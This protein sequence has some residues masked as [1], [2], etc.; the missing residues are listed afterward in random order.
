MSVKDIKKILQQVNEPNEFRMEA[1][2][3]SDQTFFIYKVQNCKIKDMDVRFDDLRPD[4]TRFDIFINGQ[5]ILDADYIF[6][7]KGKDFLIKFKKENFSYTLDG[8][9]NVFIEGD[10][11]SL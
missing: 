8:N 5:F 3:L 7:Q 9:D 4:H 6:E 10:L 1:V 2:D 11:V